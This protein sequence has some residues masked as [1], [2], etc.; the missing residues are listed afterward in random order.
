MK[1]KMLLLKRASAAAAA[2]VMAMSAG[3]AV[4]PAGGGFGAQ[5]TASAAP[6]EG[7]A[8]CDVDGNELELNNGLPTVLIFGRPTCGNTRGTLRNISNSEALDKSLANFVYLDIDNNDVETVKTFR[9]ETDT[10]KI[11]FCSPE[12]SSV[13]SFNSLMWS[14]YSGSGSVT[15]PVIVYYDAEGNKLGDTTAFQSVDTIYG[16]ITGEDEP[17]VPDVPD[18]P[19]APNSAED[20]TYTELDDGTIEITDY[21]GTSVNV[22]IPSEIDGR[23]VTSLGDDAF[24][25][26]H[27]DINTVLLEKVV[28]PDTVTHIGDMCFNWQYRL[29]EIVIPSSVTSIG[30][31][32]LNVTAW[33]DSMIA[34]DGLVVVNDI[35]V[36]GFRAGKDVIIPEGTREINTRAFCD[37]QAERIYFPD[38][39][40]RIDEEAFLGMTGIVFYCSEG[41]VADKFA[42]ANGFETS[43]DIEELMSSLRVDPILSD[44]IDDNEYSGYYDCHTS[45]KRSYICERPEGGYYIVQGSGMVY[46][47]SPDSDDY[48]VS[49]ADP[50]KLSVY[51]Y[52]P[53]SGKLTEEAEMTDLL[54]IWGGM[55]CGSKYNFVVTGDFNPDES[56]FQAVIKV[57]KYSKD[58]QYLDK[59]VFR[60]LDT[61]LPFRAG[62]VSMAEYGDKL[63]IH[64][65]HQIYKHDDG[66]RHQTN[67]TLSIDMESMVGGTDF[68]GSYVS[69]SFDQ[70]V[71]SAD[72]YLFTL[73]LGDAYPRSVVLNCY[74]DSSSFAA[75]DILDI[76]GTTGENRTG[77]SLGG[78]E[79][80]GHDPLIFGNTID[81]ENAGSYDDQRNIFVSKVDIDNDTVSTTYLT[82]YPAGD[83]TVELSPPQVTKVS[84]D[85][86]IVMWK[87]TDVSTNDESFHIASIDKNC[88]VLNENI[89]ADGSMALSDCAPVYCSDGKIRWY[90][91]KNISDLPD[92]KNCE[93]SVFVLSPDTLLV[94]KEFSSETRPH[95]D[96][97]HGSDTEPT[98]EPQPTP[99]PEPADDRVRGDVN[100]DGEVNVTDVTLTAAHVKAISALEGDRLEAADVN[101]DGDV[102]VT[103]LSAIAAHVKGIRALS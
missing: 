79:L 57:A 77:V 86:F 41:S 82:S 42:K 66:L 95:E 103:D 27:E 20:F 37:S 63:V 7:M 36:E 60:G 18:T 80:S 101:G 88:V 100:G 70:Y 48:Q 67:L 29:G 68:P 39:I 81:Q 34:R 17:E 23:T 45:P 3:A 87:E 47:T 24:G 49:R 11:S 69:H 93:L 58:W 30:R 22:V 19:D 59:T 62:T 54:P 91:A 2:L 96:P 5:M 65:C 56:S 15:L 14:L 75:Y 8:I 10:D 9:D 31:Y 52:D 99:E 78:L 12:N 72:G 50:V 28:I 16:Y 21:V 61:Y 90:T 53:E 89:I 46:E 40:E 98:P 73:D 97:N 6:L 92:E 43:Y 64:T 71:K 1:R 51:G 76:Q 85:K 25:F 35:V 44:N 26:D 38:S 74:N 4:F 84:D 13:D 55:Y 94:E 33:M 32:A 83:T 102:N